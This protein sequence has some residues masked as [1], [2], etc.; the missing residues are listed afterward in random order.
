MSYEQKN[1][2]LFDQYC[3]GYIE[4]PLVLPAKRRIIVFGDIHGDYNLAITLLKLG[5]V[6]DDNNKWIGGDTY[7]VQVGDQLDN[8]RPIQKSTMNDELKNNSKYKGDEPEDIKVLKLFT[9]LDKQ[10]IKENGGVISLL[11]NHELMNVLGDFRYVSNNDI[12]KFKNYKKYNNF[13]NSKDARL[14]AFKPGHEY[15]KFLACTRLSSV[16][17]GSFIFVHAGIFPGINDVD[18]LHKVNYIVKKWLLG[19]INK[20]NV[21]SILSSKIFFSTFWDRILGSIPP[22]MNN[23]DERC[24]KYLDNVFKILYDKNNINI[25]SMVIGHTPQI[26]AN[27]DGINSACDNKVWRVDFGG[28]FSFDKF[29]KYYDNSHSYR[30]P[31]ILEILNDTDIK[32]LYA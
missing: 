18:D 3:K 19:L 4:A 9:D 30:K 7:I 32:I 26:Y 8:Y 27:S 21:G 1:K 25:K 11:G 23:N 2:Q 28:S 6:I 16:I 12:E 31:Q 5:K 20:K 10:A 13:E 24:Q 15:A 22:N 17:I 29:D 14:D